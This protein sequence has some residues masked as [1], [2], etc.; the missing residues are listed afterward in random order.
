M[1]AKFISTALTRSQQWNGNEDFAINVYFKTF[2]SDFITITKAGYM[3]EVEI[4]ISVSDFQ[5]DFQKKHKIYNREARGYDFFHKHEMIKSGEYGLKTFSFATPQ[6]LLKIHEVPDYCGFYEI[7]QDGIVS[8][9]R[10]PPI[11]KNPQKMNKQ[12]RCKL[13]DFYKW[14]WRA[15]YFGGIE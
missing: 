7:A 15:L 3:H 14:R 6:G 1:N 13:N 8:L 10:K 5:A 9:V 12:E 4:K 2:E 11:L